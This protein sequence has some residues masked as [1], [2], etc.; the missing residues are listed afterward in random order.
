MR[1]EAIT[2]QRWFEMRLLFDLSFIF[3]YQKT[4][5]KKKFILLLLNSNVTLKT[6]WW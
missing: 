1:I 6:N 5:Y 2:D 3:V 4:V